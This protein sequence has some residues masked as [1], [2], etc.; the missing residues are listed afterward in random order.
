MGN[1]LFRVAA[2][3]GHDRNVGNFT[4]R[5][6]RRRDQNQLLL[7]FNRRLAV[8]EVEDRADLFQHKQLAKIP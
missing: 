1:T 6:A 2:D 5:T 8:E 7:F 3:K 4:A